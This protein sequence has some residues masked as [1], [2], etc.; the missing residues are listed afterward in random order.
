MDHVSLLQKELKARIDFLGPAHNNIHGNE[1]C[2]EAY[3]NQLLN[4]DNCEYTHIRRIL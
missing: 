3:T 4:A 2:D 1:I